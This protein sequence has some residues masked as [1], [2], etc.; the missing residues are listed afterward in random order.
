VPTKE[1]ELPTFSI[2]VAIFVI[3]GL[4]SISNN[5]NDGVLL[6]DAVANV[7]GRTIAIG[8]LACIGRLYKPNKLL[9]FGIAA[10]LF[11]MLSIVVQNRSKSDSSPMSQNTVESASESSLPV[12]PSDR[13]MPSQPLPVPEI[14]LPTQKNEEI[15]LTLGE[16]ESKINEAIVLFSVKLSED[17]MQGAQA[18]SEKCAYDAARSPR[19]IDTDF[20]VAFD[21]SA[22]Y[23]DTSVASAAG[24]PL[25]EYF[26]DRTLAFDREYSRFNQASSNRQSIIWNEVKNGLPE[27]MRLTRSN[28]EVQ[29]EARATELT[30]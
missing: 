8:L 4:S 12:D 24:T 1:T 6:S 18:F 22:I 15:P 26:V 29:T 3:I 17:G 9:G 30:K 21:M 28:S 5:H 7:L 16:F 14:S 11:T 13:P 19:I 25:N 2:L 23:L 20:C 10:I 27:A